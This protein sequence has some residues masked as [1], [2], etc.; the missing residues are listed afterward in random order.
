MS[1]GILELIPKACYPGLGFP[2]YPG[3]VSAMDCTKEHTEEAATAAAKAIVQQL[4]DKYAEIFL[5]DTQFLLSDTPTIA[6]FRFAPLLVFIKVGCKLPDRI[7]E[8][9]DE[10]SKLDGFTEGCQGAIDFS[11]KHWKK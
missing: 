6:D 9:Y 10:M 8:Y 1:T 5:K 11:S 3:D 7:Q 2:G 4:N